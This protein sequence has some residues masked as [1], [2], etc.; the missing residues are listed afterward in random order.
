[1]LK[2]RFISAS[3]HLERVTLRDSGMPCSLPLC[4]HSV[5]SLSYRVCAV[6]QRQGVRELCV[7]CETITRVSDL[8][9]V[10]VHG[11]TASD[12]S[13]LCSVVRAHESRHPDTRR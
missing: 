2:V 7:G 1:M 3:S 13:A 4:S 10:P 11:V 8:I 9:S 5:H 6:G 12:L